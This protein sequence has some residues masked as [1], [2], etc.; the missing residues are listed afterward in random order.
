MNNIKKLN[1]K[2]GLLESRID[3][4]ETE[5]SFLNRRLID[6]GF[7]DGIETLKATVEEYLGLDS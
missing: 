3:Q 7:D 4:L 5:L 6:C 2:I 1:I